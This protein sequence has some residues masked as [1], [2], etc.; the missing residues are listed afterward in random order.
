MFESVEGITPPSQVVVLSTLKA[1]P[2]VWNVMMLVFLLWLV[3]S[4]LGVSLFKGK[5]RYCSDD[6]LLS[7]VDCEAAGG[8]W[9]GR[10]GVSFDS[11]LFATF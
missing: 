1:L 9:Q 5:L 7:M 2:S 11:T 3:F 6:V 8:L 10:D 4:I